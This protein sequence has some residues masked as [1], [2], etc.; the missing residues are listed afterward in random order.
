MEEQCTRC[1]E[2]SSRNVVVRIIDE[3]LSYSC[4]ECGWHFEPPHPFFFEGWYVELQQALAP[5][6]ILYSLLSNE[7]TVRF[8]MP[9]LQGMSYL[10]VWAKE[11]KIGVNKPGSLSYDRLGEEISSARDIYLSQQILIVYAYAE[12][13]LDDFLDKVAYVNNPMARTA[14]KDLQN[15]GL[16]VII[17]SWVKEYKIHL[18]RPIINEWKEIRKKRNQIA[19]EVKSIQ[20]SLNTVNEAYK[21]LFYLLGTLAEVAIRVGIPFVDEF[22]LLLTIRKQDI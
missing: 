1:L 20:V 22:D 3:K 8:L 2:C 10:S 17:E 12:T 13:I 18:S 21:T 19:H 14:R 5:V 7:E 9:R 6:D 16:E 15:K 11:S 4:N